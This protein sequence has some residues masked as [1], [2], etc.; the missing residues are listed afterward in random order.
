[1]GREVRDLSWVPDGFRWCPTC[2]QAVAH[3]DYARSSITA[4]GFGS[5]CRACKN[6]ANSDA[7]FYRTYGLTR[8]AL[9][10][11]RDQQSDR[12]AIC[13][14]PSPQHLDHDHQTGCVRAL[15]CQRCNHALGLFRDEP[16]FLRA[17]ADYVER[18]RAGQ[19]AGVGSAGSRPGTPGRPGSP[20]VGSA[21]RP[22]ASR[23]TGRNST[24]S[25]RS[26]AGEAD[27]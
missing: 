9:T 17:A 16:R 2:E 6:E 21:G 14:D 1:M 23:R 24:N 3:A 15:L 26:A 11:L 5:Q 25:R 12:C 27:T 19:V 8:R 13:A 4:S 22:S 10:E 18:H 20:P 7:Y